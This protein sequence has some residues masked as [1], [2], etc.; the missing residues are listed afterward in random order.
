MDRNI[1]TKMKRRISVLMATVLLALSCSQTA[2]AAT[3]TVTS[4]SITLDIDLIAGESLPSLSTGY[5]SD[6]GCEVKVPSNNKYDIK[7]VKWDKDVD[8][9]K[10]GTSYTLKIYL[11]PMNDYKFSGSYSSSNVKVKGG[12]LVSARRVS[13]NE[14]LVTVKSK[15]AEGDF[16]SPDDAYWLDTSSRSKFGQARWSKVDNAAYDVYLYRGSKIVEKKTKVTGT[17]YNFYPY[18]TQ[19]GTYTFRVRAVAPNSDVSKYAKDSD[20]VV[21]NEVYIGEEDVSDGSG[22]DSSNSSG[23]SGTNSPDTPSGIYDVG[24]IKENNYWY[25]RYPDGTFIK[26][27]WSKI[28][29]FWYLF[30]SNGAMLTGWQNRNDRTYYLKPSGE[31]A[32]GWMQY[33]NRWYYLNPQ[34]N[35]G[36]EGAMVTG[37]LDLGGKSYYLNSDGTMAEGWQEVDG[38]WFYFYP[39]DGRKAVDTFID[40]FY[41]DK[42]GV[43]HKPD[44]V[45]R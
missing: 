18:M 24:W 2:F 1:I 35:T 27:G 36:V 19:K 42:E 6:S 33:E 3:S 25:F 21:S 31:M 9:A 16:E 10:L 45:D 17:S 22:K 39:G 29:E 41:V 15:A 34:D 26:N 28:G 11:E 38:S 32:K 5:T 23:S 40:I 7:S 44:Q 43:W 14:L 12:T 4:V 37:W 13:S 30:D 20:W 8:E